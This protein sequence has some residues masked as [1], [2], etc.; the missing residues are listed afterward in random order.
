MVLY[1]LGYGVLQGVRVRV[2]VLYRG[3]GLGLWCCT[4]S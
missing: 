2:M 3:L 4:G 1:M